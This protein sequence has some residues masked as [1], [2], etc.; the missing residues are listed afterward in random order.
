MIIRRFG[1]LILALLLTVAVIPGAARSQTPPQPPEPFPFSDRYPAEVVLGSRADLAI[2]YHLNIDVGHVRPG[3][4][5][6][7]LVATVYV[8][9]GEAQRLAQE[10][11][12]ARV[13]P[14]ESLRAFRQYGP[15]TGKPKAWPTFQ[16]FV[17]RM[18]GIA[19]AHPDI[20]RLVSIGQSVQGRDIW[21]LRITD[22]P[23]AEEDEPEFK[24]TSTMH[25]DEPVGT[26]MTLRLA[27]LLTA[28]Y[29]T[30]PDLTA[31]VDEMEIWL[32]PIHNPDGYV[33][34][35]RYNAHGQDL[36]R[37]FP[38]RITDPVDD[39]AGREPETQA[40]MNLG[41]AHRFVMGANYHGGAQVVNYPWDSVPSPPDYAPDDALFY[42]YSVGYAVR[43]PMIWNGGFPSGV[44][45]GWEWY[46]IRGGMQ[47]WAYYWRGEHHVT[48]ELSNTKYPPYDQMDTYWNAN[49]D[50]MPWW[51]GRALTGVRGL[52]TDAAT[53]APLDATVDVLEIGQPVRTDPDVGDYHRLL[54][55]G[56]Y[57][58]QASATG[59]LTQTAA[60]TVI[61]GTTIVRH[62]QLVPDLPAPPVTV[63][64]TGP[65]TGFVQ[66]GYTF[67]A[68]TEPITTLTPLDYVWHAAGQ[69]PTK[70]KSGL[71]DTVTLAWDTPGIQSITV[72]A[73]NAWGTVTATHAITLSAL[74]E[75]HVA[76]PATGVVG[77]DCAFTVT[78]TPVT[79]TQP[80]TYVWQATGAAPVT[81][82]G[83][84]SD[85]AVL[86]WT[87]AG[88]Q[89]LTVTA[90]NAEVSAYG[91]AVVELTAG[92]LD[93]IAVA[94]GSVT[95]TVGTTQSF[96]ASGADA[97][98]NVVPISPTWATDAGTM[99]GDLL[100]AQTTPASGRHVT[101]TVDAV[102]GVAL[103]DVVAGPLSRL[104]IAPP[105]ATVPMRG[106]QQFSA[107]GF[108]AYGNVVAGVPLSW[109]VTQPDVGAIDA[110]GLFTA[111]TRAGEYPGAVVVASGVISATA[112]VAVHWPYQ[113]YLPLVMRS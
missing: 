74:P 78:V 51:M 44:T 19:N 39:P 4:A 41:Y 49:R 94:P 16:Q 71:T 62:F 3:P 58:L 112:D 80:I 22:N 102:R 76:G 5:A 52:V 85:T 24:Y 7:S 67:V 83:G 31:L 84:L 57:T 68:T 35:S 6:P 111:G 48:I 2:L 65:V 54:L 30:D 18:E 12:L 66:T 98:G 15:G 108:D 23:D 28:N 21:L 87:V 36:N 105:T 92:P 99:A 93:R 53:S 43:N 101:A 79:T 1:S 27:E 96:A 55:P 100:T 91:S 97:F 109:W 11:L 60:V 73:A 9:A 25:G 13:V 59:Y 63:T 88:P 69:S 103:V 75:V 90:T 37:D 107:A 106:Q 40:F 64:V 95:V 70:H 17:A 86:S 33:V 8:N 29:G 81:H 34:G 38:D 61:S 113:I 42:D 26:E 56:A 110:A 89:P 10:G 104:A 50:A 82:T 46:I 72:T 45:R 77:A 32:C 20:V 47:D 14:N